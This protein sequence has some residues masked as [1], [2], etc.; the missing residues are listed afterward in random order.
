MT[1]APAAAPAYDRADWASAFRN[2]GVELDGVALTAA[3]GTI[4]PELEGTLYRNG[5]GRLERGGHWVHHP[6]D[7]DGMITALRFAG[8]QAELRNRFVRTEGWQAEEA[9]DKFLYRGV[10]GT[11]KPG[12]IAANAF[13]LRLKNIANTHVVCLGDQLLALWEAAEPHA[14][15][16]D[17]LET[18]GLSRLDGLLKKGEAFS[19]HPRFDPG[20]HGEPRMVTF[21]V[22]AG[23]RSTIRLMEFSSAGTLLADSKHSFKGFAF[24]HDF[25]IT[26]NW[27]VFLQNAVAFNPT[28][29]VLG[30]KGAAQCL[31]SKPGEHGQFWLIPR[32]SGSAA[33]REPLQIAAPEGFVFHHLNAFEEGDELVVDSIYYADFP[34]IGPDV[35]FRQVDFE[36]IPEGQLVR[37]RINLT[38]GSVTSELL[39]ERTC[40]FAM[41]NPARQGLD[42]HVSWMAVAERERGNDPLQAIKKLD[43]R[44]GDGRVWS[45]APRGF[46]SEPVM[47]PRPGATAEDDGWVLCLVW[48]GARCASDLVILDAASM[49]EVAVLELPL[50]V[51][52][53][54]H[55]SWA[56]ASA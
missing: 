21:G 24:L 50:A 34:S 23:P 31:S 22:K 46:V 26:P 12:G 38:D 41:V 17:T 5:P 6:F 49:A 55:G 28:G 14:L 8:G 30:Q 52:H 10:F 35:D 13:D 1:A 9:A 32:S 19:A 42:A 29:F 40:E 51:P 3:R 53:G 56:P 36:S 43:L 33:G 25:A 11:Q 2:V 7:G 39:E 37:C 44:T 27:A 47:V 15:D 48:N 20:H 16:P 4:P 54:L 45:A 18:R